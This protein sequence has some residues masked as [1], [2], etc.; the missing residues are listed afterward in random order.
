[1]NKSSETDLH[2]EEQLAQ[3]ASRGS[4]HLAKLIV[5]KQ[6]D[7]KTDSYAWLGASKPLV[8]PRMCSK[9]FPV[10]F[11]FYLILGLTVK[12]L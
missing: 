9:S 10:N 5:F 11:P 12:V 2:A 7:R 8:T 4:L 6:N 1:M 3:P